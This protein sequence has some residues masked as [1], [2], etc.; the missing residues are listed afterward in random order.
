[1]TSL[2]RLSDLIAES[3]RSSRSIADR[4]GALGTPL[5]F[6]TRLI[7]EAERFREMM[8]E[9]DRA[10]RHAEE[11][12]DM[13]RAVIEAGQ[14]ARDLRE[15]RSLEA[16]EALNREMQRQREWFTR[17]TEAAAAARDFARDIA[18]MEARLAVHLAPSLSATR[19]IEQAVREHAMWQDHFRLPELF[20]A[21]VS[22]QHGLA[23]LASPGGLPFAP[24][25]VEESNRAIQTFAVV[26]R[27]S[28]AAEDLVADTG[29]APTS[30][31]LESRLVLVHEQLVVPFRGA[32]QSLESRN[33]DRVRHVGASLRTLG[34]ELLVLLA[35]DKHLDTFFPNPADH[36]TDGAYTRRARLRFVFR[37]L[38]RGG[39]ATLADQDID[40]MLATFFPE[41]AAVH[42]LVPTLTDVEL[43]VLVRRVE[44]CVSVVLAAAGY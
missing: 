44:G 37:E 2:D 7:E 32:I 35:P 4:L 34:D 29:S 38:N 18:D 19:V 28:V 14:L 6:E 21:T 27:V 26:S 40:L 8:G 11:F 10:R 12:A 23:Q 15:L 20:S 42:E 1:M 16:V 31:E 41:N 36:K 3:E 33:P 17:M 24:W 22:F 13:Q 30:V 9:V 43:N 39:Y 5:T 25:L